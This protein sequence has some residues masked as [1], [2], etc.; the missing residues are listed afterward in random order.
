MGAWGSRIFDDDEACDVRDHYREL[1]EDGVDD[2]EATRLTL[3][4]FD[5]MFKD[6]ELNSAGIVAFAVTQSKIGRLEPSIRDRALAWI[7][8]GGDLD[9]WAEDCPK[10][11]PK[12]KAAIAKARDQLT[13]P[14]PNR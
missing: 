9:V 10:D 2:V 3:E 6:P 1:I 7:D 11:L 13:A 12:R 4:K 8:K 14:Q 5:A